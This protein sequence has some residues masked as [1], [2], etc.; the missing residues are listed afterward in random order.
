MSLKIL[1][2]GFEDADLFGPC[3]PLSLFEREFVCMRELSENFIG[4]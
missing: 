3:I 2:N 4:T 1:E